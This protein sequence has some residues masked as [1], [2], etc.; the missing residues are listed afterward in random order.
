MIFVMGFY[1]CH[2]ETT[3][4]DTAAFP[5][6]PRP[7]K[8]DPPSKNRVWNFFPDSENRVGQNPAFAQCSRREKSLVVTIIASDHPLWPNRDPIDEDGGLNLYGFVGNNGL[9]WVDILG[10][11]SSDCCGGRKRPRGKRGTQ[12]VCCD[13]KWISRNTEKGRDCTSGCPPGQR[14]LPELNCLNDC[15]KTWLIDCY[16]DNRVGATLGGLGFGATGQI[17]NK[18]GTKFRAGAA[19]G[20]PSGSRTS[21]TRELARRAGHGGTGRFATPTGRFARHVGRTSTLGMAAAW[22]GVTLSALHAHCLAG[23]AGCKSGCPKVCRS[24]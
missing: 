8:Q 16:E 13:G 17:I 21:I 6:H 2:P 12:V 3:S 22:S 14:K 4:G 19:G 7:A 10:L 18:F 24:K 9:N 11:S 20:G 5:A 23:Y 15:R 1:A